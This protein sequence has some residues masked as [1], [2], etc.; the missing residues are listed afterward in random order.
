[1][2][3]AELVE[4]AREQSRELLTELPR[5]WAHVQGVATAAASAARSVASADESSIIAAA[6]LHDVGY[7]DSISQTGF[8][9]LDGATYARDAGLPA[10]V[11]SL[12]AY[13]TGAVEEAMERGLSADLAEIPQPPSA[14]LD[15]L[16]F[17]DLTTSPDGKPV[18]A[19][20]RIEEILSRYEPSD[21]VHRAVSRSA[22]SLLE[23]V[24]RVEAR[25]AATNS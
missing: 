5:R 3:D 22:P 24:A 8:H 9:P 14:V 13:H 25:I 19:S 1:M 11:V 10:L 15:V 16:T 23:A 2:D 20:D 6:W 4:S 12:I 17:A 21:P 7:S 18:E